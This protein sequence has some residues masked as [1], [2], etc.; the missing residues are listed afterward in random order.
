M[1]EPTLL[2]SSIH[3]IQ[4]SGLST[5]LTW[6]ENR[7]KR[8]LISAC[9]KIC[10]DQRFG[11]PGADLIG[12]MTRLPGRGLESGWAKDQSGSLRAASFIPG[13][14]RERDGGLSQSNIIGEEHAFTRDAV[15]FISVDLIEIRI[16]LS[17]AINHNDKEWFESLTKHHILATA[18]TWTSQHV[19]ADSSTFEPNWRD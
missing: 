12:E 18:K 13:Q 2:R 17:R 1:P 8:T 7:L 19:G 5:V 11:T 15:L 10:V 6:S 9:T 16:E 4:D 14:D 3:S